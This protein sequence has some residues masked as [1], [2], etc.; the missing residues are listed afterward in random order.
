MTLILAVGTKNKCKVAAVVAVANSIPPLAGS[1]AQV[2]SYGVSSGIPDQP[3]TLEVTRT[4]AI[5]RARA[6]FLEA[7]KAAPKDSSTTVL[8]VG[9]ESGLFYPDGETGRAFDVC[10]CMATT[11]GE[12]FNMG[13]SCAFE[14]PAPVMV[15]VKE[16]MDLSQ[17][18]NA[19]GLTTDVNLGENGGLIGILS[20]GRVTRQMYTEQALQMALFFVE[21]EELYRRGAGEDVSS[22]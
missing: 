14:I 18:C 7:R 21:N 1:N 19:A 9:I 22:R 2:H 6:A 10:V 5:N 4:G 12:T 17:A 8:A 20:K 13:L 15:F 16:G 3:L 11:D